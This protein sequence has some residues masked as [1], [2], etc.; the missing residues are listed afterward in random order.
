MSMH[1]TL[2]DSF[3][4]LRQWRRRLQRQPFAKVKNYSIFCRIEKDH[5]QITSLLCSRQLPLQLNCH[6]YVQVIG[7]RR[8]KSSKELWYKIWEL[9]RVLFWERLR[10]LEWRLEPN[11]ILHFKKIIALGRIL[12]RFVW[13]E[14]NSRRWQ[15]LQHSACLISKAHNNSK[16]LPNHLNHLQTRSKKTPPFSNHKS[17]C[18]VQRPKPPKNNCHRPTQAQATL[19]QS[20]KR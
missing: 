8:E 14:I 20:F 11:R 10:C 13:K 4:T 12:L 2:I 9:H 18:T 19:N 6:R 17:C 16:W 7:K 5:S 15:L 1:S 3:N